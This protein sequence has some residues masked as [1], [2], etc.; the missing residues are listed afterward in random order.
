MGFLKIS[1]AYLFPETL[2][3]KANKYARKKESA[4]YNSICANSSL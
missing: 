4:T 1:H 2:D 3:A